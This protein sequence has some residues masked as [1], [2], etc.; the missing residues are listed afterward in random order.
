LSGLRPW[1]E[2]GFMPNVVAAEYRGGYRIHLRFND[3]SAKVVDFRKWLEGPVFQ[4]LKD[5]AY[6]ER[7][8]VEGG[9]V[10]WPNGADIAPETLYLDKGIRERRPDKRMRELARSATARRRR[11]RR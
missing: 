11:S 9:T 5:P 2:L 1:N 10:T 4:P 3:N 8:F 7:F 6:F